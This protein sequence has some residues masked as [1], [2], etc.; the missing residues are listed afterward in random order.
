MKTRLF[1]T[2]NDYCNK[3]GLPKTYTGEKSSYTIEDVKKAWKTAQL[4]IGHGLYE[5]LFEAFTY[6]LTGKE[7]ISLD[8]DK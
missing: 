4:L 8:S 2:S 7:E 5:N 3:C 6:A 1:F